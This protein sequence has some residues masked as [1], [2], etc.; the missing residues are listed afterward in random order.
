M[1]KH[2]SERKFWW[3]LA[4]SY[5][6]FTL[7]SLFLVTVYLLITVSPQAAVLREEVIR[8]KTDQLT[9]LIAEELGSGERKVELEKVLRLFSGPWDPEIWVLGADGTVIMKSPKAENSAHSPHRDIVEKTWQG[10]SL[11]GVIASEKMIYYTRPVV[12]D[13]KILGIVYVNSPLNIPIKYRLRAL[14]PLLRAFC[15]IAFLAIFVSAFMARK[16]IYPLEEMTETAR[17]LGEG[18]L[19]ARLKKQTW[20]EE[21]EIMGDTLNTMAEKLQTS[22]LAL[23]ADKKRLEYM[24]RMRRDLIA[25]IS[26][27]IRT[28]LSTIQGC[29]EALQD[30]VVT[31]ADA[32]RYIDVIHQEVQHL[33]S[34]ITDLLEL[35]KMEARAVELHRESFSIRELLEEIVR[36][37]E[38]DLSR[39][40]MAP[41]FEGDD[42]LIN[43]D[44]DKLRQVLTNLIKNSL[45]FCPPETRVAVSAKKEQHGLVITYED[46]GPGVPEDDLGR[47]FEHFYRVEKSRSKTRGGFGLGL[48]IVKN[49]VELHGGTVTAEKAKEGGLRFVISLPEQCPGLRADN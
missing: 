34:L 23:E 11:S 42:T 13:G 9:L 31:G 12:Q 30:G 49:I 5:F 46:N 45:K 44:R 27:E 41:Q 3:K 39:S 29:S 14:A 18:E 48:A 33:S 36:L 20:S 21:M 28:P 7:G 47:L 25:S 15:L 10:K 2:R 32:T 4:L 19:T 40:K 1:N 24:E 38:V 16:I 6:F 35:E 26:H 17:K 22:L 43:A 37:M 8:K